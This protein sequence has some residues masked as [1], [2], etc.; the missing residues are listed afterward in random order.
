M[1]PH[2]GRVL[3]SRPDGQRAV[4]GAPICGRRVGVQDRRPEQHRAPA[5][6]HGDVEPGEVRLSSLG[7]V[8]Q[9]EEGRVHARAL[10]AGVVVRSVVLARSIAQQLQSLEVVRVHHEQLGEARDEPAHGGLAAAAGLAPVHVCVSVGREDHLRAAVLP[11]TARVRRPLPSALAQQHGDLV[12]AER[13]LHERHPRARAEHLMVCVSGVWLSLFPTNCTPKP[14]L[15]YGSCM[16]GRT[17][18]IMRI[19]RECKY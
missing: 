7:D 9:V 6:P 1:D 15:P 19:V 5:G 16:L 14:S 17:G 10:T 12:V 11:H 4:L 2:V 8:G 3:D 13:P 18:L